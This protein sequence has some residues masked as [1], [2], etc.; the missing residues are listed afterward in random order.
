MIEISIIF[1]YAIDCSCLCQ[2]SGNEVFEISKENMLCR[3]IMM[4]IS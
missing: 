4:L 1:T 2:L 3:I